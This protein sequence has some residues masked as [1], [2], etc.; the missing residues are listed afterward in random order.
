MCTQFLFSLLTL[1]PFADP[2]PE[3]LWANGA[4]GLVAGDKDR[5]NLTAY[6]PPK[7]RAN[8]C[9]VVV[10]PGGGY[11]FLADN[12]EGRDVCKWL[13][14]RGV[15]AF[16]LRYR[17]VQKDRPGP[18]HPYPLMDAQRAIRYVRANA[19]KYGVDPKR[20]GIW[21][22]SAGGH[23]AS[24]AVTHFDSGKAD[25]ADPV[26][27][28]SS[29]PDFGILAY[30]VISFKEPTVHKGSRTNLIGPKPEQKLIDEYSNELKVTKDT[31]PCFLFHTAEDKGVPVENSRLFVAACQ[32]HKVPVEL[33]IFENGRHGVGL[34]MRDDKELG[35]KETDPVL[36]KWPVVLEAWM[37]KMGLFTSK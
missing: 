26:E 11:G 25:S 31:P 10:C 35:L 29:R 32:K 2:T 30:P 27:A 28:F 37:Q 33:V 24:T 21:G 13:N 34:G 4:P 20:V 17:I 7:E 9:G 19:E 16:I 5:P 36:S 22:F 6:L 18:L 14:E 8:G 3:P 23:L 15:A 1:V 12:H